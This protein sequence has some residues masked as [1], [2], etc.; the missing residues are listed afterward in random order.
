MFIYHKIIKKNA[1]VNT[2]ANPFLGPP[3]NLFMYVSKYVYI[4]LPFLTVCMFD[5]VLRRNGAQKS[6]QLKVW[7]PSM[8]T[9]HSRYRTASYRWFLF[10]DDICTFKYEWL[11]G[12]LKK[13]ICLST[14]GLIK[15]LSSM[16]IS[17]V[18][19]AHAVKKDKVT[20]CLVCGGC[21]C[22][23]IFKK[24]TTFSKRKE[25]FQCKERYF[26]LFKATFVS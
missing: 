21:I 7:W 12:I 17:T 1:S 4:I 20:G 23:S 10:H 8:P 24:D 2:C 6:V 15:I 22:C 9:V 16:C 11:M 3:S 25:F 13:I 5:V 26:M 18:H 14:D 19:G